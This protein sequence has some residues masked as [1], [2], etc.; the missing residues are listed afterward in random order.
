MN[1]LSLANDLVG[2]TLWISGAGRGI[3]L[4]CSRLFRDCGCKVVAF[5][6]EPTEE[7]AEVAHTVH[8]VDVSDAAAL[9]AFAEGEVNVPD[10]L[11]NNAGITRDKVVWKLSEEDWDNV[12]DVSLK[13]AFTLSRLAIPHMREKERGS[14][15]N[16]TSINGLRGKFGQSNYCAAKAGLI[17]FT[18]SVAREV[19]R[20]G[21][22]MNAI[23]PGMVETEMSRSLPESVK[24]QALDESLLGRLANVENIA[25]AAVFLASSFSSHVTGQVLNVDGGQYL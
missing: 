24:Q 19:G 7:L 21:V 2:R 16:I 3:G 9:N 6:L 25:H 1:T 18:K 11:I 10:I 8:Q 20:F 17:G 5:E 22:R 14:I 12:I 15:I 13:A 23:A 4:G